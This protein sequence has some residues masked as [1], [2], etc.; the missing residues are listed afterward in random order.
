MLFCFPTEEI[1]QDRHSNAFPGYCIAT[2]KN[3]ICLL[4]EVP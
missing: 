1:V 4:K 3:F 2:A